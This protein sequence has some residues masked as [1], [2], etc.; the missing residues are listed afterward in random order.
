MGQTRLYLHTA[1]LTATML[2]VAACGT[3]PGAA[4]QPSF[5]T[6]VPPTST[7]GPTTARAPAPTDT[8]GLTL[9]GYRA[10]WRNGV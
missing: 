4:S 2:L 8:A 9:D 3:S 6:P 7:V 5:A 1:A 10:V